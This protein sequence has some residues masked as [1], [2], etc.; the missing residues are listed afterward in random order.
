MFC[1]L[2]VRP[3]LACPVIQD[4]R[5]DTWEDAGTSGA[6]MMF[7]WNFEFGWYDDLTDEV[8]ISA[9]GIIALTRKW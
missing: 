6:K 9:G 5:K 4:I 8:P 1:L 7:E 2:L 3:S